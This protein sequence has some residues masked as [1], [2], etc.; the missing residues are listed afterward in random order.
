MLPTDANVSISDTT[1][2][3]SNI[4]KGIIENG[5]RYQAVREG[6]YW[7]PSDDKQFQSMNLAYLVYLVL[8]SQE[9]N[10]FFRSPICSNPQN[11]LDL[12]TGQGDWVCSP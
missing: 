1:S 8:D 5:R 6:E 4:Y 11:I 2:V 9:E 3:A 7:G 10:P 12:G